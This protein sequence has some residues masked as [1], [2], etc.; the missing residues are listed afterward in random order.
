MDW[1]K[2]NHYVLEKQHLKKKCSNVLRCVDDIAGLNSI[3]ATTPYLSLFNRIKDFNKSA[4]DEE[5]YE[6]KRLYR[7]RLMRSTLFIVSESL[8]PIAYSATIDRTRKRLAGFRKY[9]RFSEREFK[10]LK[11]EIIDLLEKGEKTAA[12]IKKELGTTISISRVVR[13]LME[14]VPLLRLKPLGTWKGEQFRYS[15]LPKNIKLKMSK[16]KAK[17]LLAEK[18]LQSFGPV[19]LKDL[20]WWSGF[21]KKE[22]E[23]ILE[24]IKTIDVGD[25][26]LLLEKEGD[27]FENFK[28]DDEHIL[29]L[30]SFD[31]YVITYKYSVYP[32]LV[33]KNHLNRIYNEYG[34]L[35]DPIIRKGRII[36]RWWLKKRKMGYILYDK[37]VNKKELNQ[38]IE[39]MEEFLRE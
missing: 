6:K 8:L 27:D 1:E 23:K 13:L 21:S 17:V 37:V 26:L 29:L 5:L 31:Q 19:T 11:D 30:S 33:T 7:L 20:A 35:H 36:G 22:S 10:K 28:V 4:L 39:E 2:I 25:G 12:E 18:F 32:R 24:N 34:E 16:E 9:Y 14:D 3:K 38:K 15:L